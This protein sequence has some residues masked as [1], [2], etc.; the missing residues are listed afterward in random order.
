M[1]HTTATLAIALGLA[2]FGAAC[3]SSNGTVLSD[4]GS[5]DTGTAVSTTT[6]TDQTSRPGPTSDCDV[7]DPESLAAPDTT[8]RFYAACGD[9]I[10]FPIFRSAE[11]FGLDHS[12]ELMAQGL[13]DQEQEA[14]LF[15]WFDPDGDAGPVD[16]EVSIDGDGVALLEFS[17][18]EGPWQPGASTSTQTLS[19]VDPLT[20]TVFTSLDVTA[21]DR[22]GLC[23]GELSCQGLLTRDEYQQTMFLN[24]GVIF[25]PGCDEVG[26][27]ARPELCRLSSIIEAGDLADA[28]VTG[29]AADDVLNMRA[30]PGADAFEVGVALDPGAAVKATPIERL[31]ADGGLWR[32]VVDGAGAGGWVNTAFLT[33]E[34][35][36]PEQLAD[37]FVAFAKDPTAETLD[38]LPMADQVSLGLGPTL[39]TT[40]PGQELLDPATWIMDVEEF[41]AYVG[42]FPILGSLE[43]EDR[44][45]VEVGHHRHCAGDPMPV[46]DGLQSA[47]QISIQPNEA[48]I[49]SCL[50]WY[51]VDLFVGADDTIEAVTLDLWEP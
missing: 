15:S 48:T 50:Q 40:V 22:S 33:V 42:P 29:V 4:V 43:T 21:I 44:W 20:A 5:S 51:T 26:F 46:P 34:R 41:R 8:I 2:I 9:T 6:T 38:A 37:R 17:T 31:A 10:P 11:R 28:T 32:V 35:S 23:F 27:W 45:Q 36:G 47:T 12:L 13:T 1:R 30:G 24:H 7:T 49:D 25:N 3:S 18:A 16:V 39:L 19:L 14:G